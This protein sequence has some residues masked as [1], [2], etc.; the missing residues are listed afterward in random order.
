MH[1]KINSDVY[2]YYIIYYIGRYISYYVGTAT[3]SPSAALVPPNRRTN[4]YYS[5][6]ELFIVDW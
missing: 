3:P 4:I 2:R 1:Q 5:A 6:Q